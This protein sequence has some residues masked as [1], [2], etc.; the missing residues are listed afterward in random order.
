MTQGLSK[1]TPISHFHM[2]YV[3][4]MSLM[5]SI[6]LK[7][8]LENNPNLVRPTNFHDRTG[9]ILP[10]NKCVISD[11]LN[12][13]SK[14]VKDHQMR[15]NEEKTKVMLF[16]PSKKWDF[17]PSVSLGIKSP[18]LEV[19]DE[20]KL[21]G[22]IITSDMKWNRNTSQLCEKWYRRLWMLRNLK[23]LGAT[24]PELLD[25]Y[26]KQ[27]RSILELA[28]PVWTPGLTND[29]ILELE[30]VQ[31]AA[32]A[33]I[34]GRNYCEYSD[35]IRVLGIKTLK[36]RRQDLCLKFAKKCIKNKEHR[37]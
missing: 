13:L 4:D 10:R 37:K 34:L 32:C 23:R 33:I 26:I 19:V 11:Q 12:Q 20:I 7:Q 25:V 5:T 17:T 30:R 8:S 21:L 14:Y 1:R 35:A 31:K 29:N 36:Q 16:N 28:A 3:D 27:C 22:I 24:V 9:H 15:I 6:D 2:K 18:N